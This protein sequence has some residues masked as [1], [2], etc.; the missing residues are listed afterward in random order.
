MTA[1]ILNARQWFFLIVLAIL[2][3][4]FTAYWVF[5]ALIKAQEFFDKRRAIETRK[6]LN[7]LIGRFFFSVFLNNEQKEGKEKDA[8]R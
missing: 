8:G 4:A 3:V 2:A 6:R 7:G 5:L 1:E